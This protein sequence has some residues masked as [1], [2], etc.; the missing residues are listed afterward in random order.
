MVLDGLKMKDSP[1]STGPSV[2]CASWIVSLDSDIHESVTDNNLS[3]PGV[4]PTPGCLQLL[5]GTDNN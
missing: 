2:V 4:S 1:L 5:P 3:T